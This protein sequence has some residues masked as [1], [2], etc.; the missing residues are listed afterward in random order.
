M[1]CR[2]ISCQWKC[3]VIINMVIEKSLDERYSLFDKPSI[4]YNGT[5]SMELS[6][7]YFKRLLVKV[8]IKMYFLPLILFSSLQTVQTLV[9]YRTIFHSS[10]PSLFVKVPIMKIT[11]GVKPREMYKMQNMCNLQ[12]I[13]LLWIPCEC[14]NNIELSMTLY[15][16]YCFR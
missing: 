16:V 13:H 10:R 3:S 7:L 12:R 2:R 5:L 15:K 1:F 8:S 14:N 11:K 6:C 9:K 4:Y